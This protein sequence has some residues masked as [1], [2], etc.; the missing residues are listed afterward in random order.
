M[1]KAPFL[2]LLETL[3]PKL[4]GFAY[5]MLRDEEQV[6]DAMQE[7]MLRLWKKRK[8]LK[9]NQNISSYAFKTLNNICID[10]IRHNKRFVTESQF[11]QNDLHP[12]SVENSLSSRQKPGPNGDH[13][14]IA[15]EHKE[16]ISRIK[17][18]VSNLPQKQRT[19]IE[20][21]DFQEF[22]HKEI[23]EMLEIEINA[24]RTNLSRARAKIQA[25]FKKEE[26]YG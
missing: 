6:K 13:I 23:A 20:L 7:L 21:H 11:L 25:Q 18:A 2:N 12:S 22:S 17:K 15:Q 5:R 14:S 10:T 8:E 16:L 26:I 24:V 9:E 19:I 4:F 1:K 3:E